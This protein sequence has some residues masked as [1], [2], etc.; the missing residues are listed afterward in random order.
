MI[1]YQIFTD[2]ILHTHCGDIGV[3]NTADLS[4]SDVQVSTLRQLMEQAHAACKDLRTLDLRDTDLEDI[5][6]D[7]FEMLEEAYYDCAYESYFEN[8]V[9]RAYD[10]LDSIGITID[11]DEVRDICTERYGYQQIDDVSESD[12]DFQ[13]W[14]TENIIDSDKLVNFERNENLMDLDDWDHIPFNAP[15]H[16]PRQ[17]VD[18]F[19]QG[20]RP[21]GWDAS[22]LKSDTV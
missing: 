10:R 15:I 4:F 7:L 11:W 13:V 21:K 12:L 9:N 18:E 20:I 14:F 22:T 2:T 5:D 17:L 1:T 8:L 19:L 3:E 16:F 6:Q